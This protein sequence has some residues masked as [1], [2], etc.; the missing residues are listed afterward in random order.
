MA[1]NEPVLRGQ[2]ALLCGSMAWSGMVLYM[3]LKKCKENQKAYTNPMLCVAFT[4]CCRCFYYVS[5]NYA[6]LLWLQRRSLL[7]LLFLPLGGP[8]WLNLSNRASIKNNMYC[9]WFLEIR[10]LTQSSNFTSSILTL[11]G[12]VFDDINNLGCI[13]LKDCHCSYN[14]DTYSPG[15]SFA[16]QCTSW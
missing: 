9:T 16:S 11:S 6:F 12:T 8:T 2:N 5:H 3:V 10:R 1:S 7:L 15:A 4:C 14:G 13:P